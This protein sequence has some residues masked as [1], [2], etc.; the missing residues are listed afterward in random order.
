MT[1]NSKMPNVARAAGAVA[2]PGDKEYRNM[3]RK[4]G[5]TLIELL[6][7]IAIISILAAIVTPKVQGYILRSRMTNTVAEI[8]GIETAMAKMLTDCG[9]SSFR[10]M[11]VNANGALDTPADN[12]GV[13]DVPKLT[14]QIDSYTK[15]F[16]ALLRQGRNV[17][18]NADGTMVNGGLKLAEG[19]KD[20]LAT[21][22]LDADRDAWD[23]QYQF[24]AGPWDRPG[25]IQFRCYRP[26]I[27]L[28]GGVTSYPY[29]YSASHQILDENG[30]TKNVNEQEEMDKK[31]PGNPAPD[32]EFGYPAPKDL[33]I[34]VFSYGVNGKNDQLFG[35]QTDPKLKGGADDINNWDM[36]EQGWTGF[37]S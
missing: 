33:N 11:F 2:N 17:S 19:V 23:R 15:A 21:S 3:T 16:Y 32:E 24:W 1:G 14:A 22:Y 35:S 6:V 29:K 28:D 31:I 12:T 27:S 34:Y 36:G 4:H 20:K 8:Q 18:L 30:Q 13:V 25:A 7:V 10:Q 37:Y 5:F 9:K 26:Y